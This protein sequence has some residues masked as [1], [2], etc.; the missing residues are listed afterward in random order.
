MISIVDGK[1]KTNKETMSTK[2]NRGILRSRSNENRKR[3][4]LSFRRT[5]NRDE[6]SLIYNGISVAN[7]GFEIARIL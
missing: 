7:S 1:H 4:I 5:S 6:A 3:K 2:I